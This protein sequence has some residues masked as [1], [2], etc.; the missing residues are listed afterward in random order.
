MSES[1]DFVVGYG[2]TFEQLEDLRREF[3][4]LPFLEECLMREL[5]E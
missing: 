1:F 2:T 5:I 4:L 3:L